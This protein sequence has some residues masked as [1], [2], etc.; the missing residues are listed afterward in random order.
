MR[1]LLGMKDRIAVSTTEAVHASTPLTPNVG[2]VF[3][4]CRGE[5]VGFILACAMALWSVGLLV[6]LKSSSAWVSFGEK[7]VVSPAMAGLAA[8]VAASIGALALKRQLDHTKTESLHVQKKDA[9]EAWWEKFEWVTDRIL[10]KDPSHMKLEK[11]LAIDLLTSLMAMSTEEFQKSAVSGVVEHYLK[12]VSEPSS[13]G[14][15]PDIRT[16]AEAK[17]VRNYIKASENA[18]VVSGVAQGALTAYEYEKAVMNALSDRD[19][20]FDMFPE[21]PDPAALTGNRRLRPDAVL[22]VES[23]RVILEIKA[24]EKFRLPA[25]EMSVARMLVMKAAAAASHGIIIT[26]VDIPARVQDSPLRLDGVRFVQWLP[27][28]GSA[29]LEQ[30]LRDAIPV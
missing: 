26:G 2:W 27:S 4:I 25:A 3:W 16:E 13:V 10:P 24:W 20:E 6:N 5:V 30:R 23:K 8:I 21:Y 12:P 7:F 19:M 9:E 17:S 18:S 29:V 14:G 28:D 11:S 1:I 22:H 15:E